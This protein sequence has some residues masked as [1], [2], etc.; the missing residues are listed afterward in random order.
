MPRSSNDVCLFLFSGHGITNGFI[1]FNGPSFAVTPSDIQTAFTSDRSSNYNNFCCFIDACN[2]G[3]FTN[4]MNRG[5]VS[6]SCT[7]DEMS[8]YN[9]DSLYTNYMGW[10]IYYI[11]NKSQNKCSLIS[12][13]SIYNYIVVEPQT[14]RIPGQHPQI[15]DYYTGFYENNLILGPKNWV[16]TGDHTVTLNSNYTALGDIEIKWSGNLILADNVTLYMNNNNKIKNYGEL[17]FG[18]YYSG[19]KI[20]KA[21]GAS[22]WSGID[23]VDTTSVMNFM[24]DSN[25]EYAVDG[26]DFTATGRIDNNDNKLTIRNCSQAG[27]WALN[28]SPYI[29]NV[30]FSNASNSTYQ[31]GAITVTGTTSHPAITRV[32]IDSTYFGMRVSSTYA[33]T[34]V[35]HSCINMNSTSYADISHSLQ[36]NT[37]GRINFNGNNNICRKSGKKAISNASSDSIHAE[38]NY[39]GMPVP[40][41]DSLF[42][43]PGL[44][45]KTGYSGSQYTTGVGAYKNAF[46]EINDPLYTARQ[47]ELLKNYPQAMSIY[48]SLITRETDPGT[49]EFIITSILRVADH[50]DR[51]YTEVRNV[52]N[53]ELT[54]AKSWYKA[55]LDFT[56]CSILYRECKY[57][58]ALD[59]FKQNAAIYKGT[60]IEL[61]Y[62]SSI[63]EL[64]GNKFNDKTSAKSYAD[65]AAAINPGD[66]ILRFAYEAAG[67]E[68]ISAKYEYKN[69]DPFTGYSDDSNPE[70]DVIVSSTAKIA[71][72]PNP[73]NPS[74]TISYSIAN[75]GHVYLSV[76]NIAGQKVAT[77]VNGNMSIGNHSV[78]FDGSNLGSGVYFYRFETG[79]FNKT[80]KMLLVK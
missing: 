47:F 30:Y 62:L 71:I 2:S 74:T 67:E 27:I 43:N 15:A 80:G 23:M 66:P 72:S 19:A 44:V 35:D 9:Q 36:I 4:N 21:S 78:S 28:C 55:C 8:D 39:W 34:S 68:Y 73:F 61:E 26:I 12:P 59:A 42:T 65:K 45:I 22:F 18:S 60:P 50:S 29:R 3:V 37:G 24:G 40:I 17:T 63:A 49:K 76:Y 13:E 48:K 31:N 32:T 16:I 14:S 41:G 46:E 53:S 56:I 25:I 69:I 79:K 1:P 38:N 20:T 57:R 6:S 64:Y 52:I 54:S 51:D 75:P 33:S 77:L 58:E 10:V 70:K 11:K 5:V 7:S